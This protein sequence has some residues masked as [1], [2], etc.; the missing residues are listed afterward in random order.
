MVDQYN[1]SVKLLALT[2]LRQRFPQDDD[3]C[4]RRC[5]ADMLSGEQ[6]A[7]S[8]MARASDD[9]KIWPEA[10]SVMMLVVNVFE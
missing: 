9:M 3:E 2:G 8:Y 4:I 1:Q 7:L 5:L 6:S 10:V